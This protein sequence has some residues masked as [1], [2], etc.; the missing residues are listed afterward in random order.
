[1]V[2]GVATAFQ[3]G[4]PGRHYGALPPAG[5]ALG[6][7]DGRAH[8]RQFGRG[9]LAFLALLAACPERRRAMS[10][11]L[12]VRGDAPPLGAVGFVQRFALTPAQRAEAIEYIPDLRLAL[13]SGGPTYLVLGGSGKLRAVST[14]GDRRDY[15]A[16]AWRLVLAVP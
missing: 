15:L 10:T 12:L 2:R 8:R 4:E 3:G 11:G 16:F 7:R 5:L 1:M 6:E 9:G 14:P 13:T